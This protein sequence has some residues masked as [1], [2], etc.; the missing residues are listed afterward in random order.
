MQD[1]GMRGTESLCTKTR[2]SKRRILTVDYGCYRFQGYYSLIYG[3]VERNRAAL[4]EAI[5]EE[6]A[7]RIEWDNKEVQCTD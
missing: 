4:I 6:I 7:R 1:C 5:K 3:N 2:K